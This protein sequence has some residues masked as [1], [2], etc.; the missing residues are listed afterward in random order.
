M[1]IN[2]NLMNINHTPQ[3]RTNSDIQFIVIHYVGAL[4]DAKANTDY[5][6]SQYVGASA[7]FWVG[8]NGDVWQGNDYRNYY[9]WAIGGGLQGN[10]PHPWFQKALNSNSVSIEMCVRKKSTA[11]MNATDK[12]WYFE[13]AT[14]ESAAELT[15]QLMKELDVDIDHVIRHYDVNAKICPNPFVYDTASVTWASFKKKVMEYFTHTSSTTPQPIQ[16]R[17]AKD[18]KNG[19]YIDQKGAYSSSTLAPIKA[20]CPVGYSVYDANGMCVYTRTASQFD[21]DVEKLKTMT[22]TDFVAYIGE[23]ASVDMQKT[24]VLSSVT[25]AQA[26]LESGYGKTDLAQGALNL[27]GMKTELSGNTWVSDW[28][29]SDVY[30]KRTQEQDSDGNVHYE[31]AAFRLY[32]SIA[33]S[34]KDHS[35][36]LLGAKN[37]TKLRYDGLKG[38][39]NYRRAITIIKDGGYATDVKYVD[40]VCSIIEKWDLTKYDGQNAAPETEEYYRVGT[41]WTGH[42]CKFQM[43]A[44]KDLANAKIMADNC[45]SAYKVFDPCGNIVYTGKDTFKPYVVQVTAPDLYIR[46]GAGTTYGTKGFTGK[47][48]FTIV[49][50]KSDGSGKKWGLL[51]SYEKDRNG[52]IALWLNCVKK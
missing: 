17:I 21:K 37:G 6:K 2:Q 16:Y 7:D 40:K 51:K 28:N 31:K 13:D 35:D 11:T 14:I 39:T 36:Y 34:I 50:E 44:Y 15:A 1:I 9:S 32:P 27:F 4:G 29:S 8:F 10:G 30:V 5:Y 25:A 23:L 24:G 49:S 19:T 45:G 3:T 47:G 33:A 52:W 18:Y 41:E 38:Q 43:G 46:S 22:E 12:D 42:G 26:I 48:T 20:S